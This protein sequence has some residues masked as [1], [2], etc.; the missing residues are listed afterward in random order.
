M[1]VKT[2]RKIEPAWDIGVT[3]MASTG[4]RSQIPRSAPS[5][6]QVVRF[7]HR[8]SASGACIEVAGNDRKCAECFIEYF[9]M[10]SAL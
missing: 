3:K 1:L 5:L 2:S 8:G 4:R 7:T 6:G 10:G 9:A